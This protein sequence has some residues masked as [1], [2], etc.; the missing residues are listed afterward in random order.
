M[1]PSTA[2]IETDEDDE[3]SLLDLLQ[4]VAGWHDYPHPHPRHCERSAAIHARQP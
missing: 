2:R 3:I 4:V 1:T